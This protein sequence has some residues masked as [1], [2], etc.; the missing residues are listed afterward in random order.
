MDGALKLLSSTVIVA[1]A[2]VGGLCSCAVVIVDA[3][4]LRGLLELPDPLVAAHG[5]NSCGLL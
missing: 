3:I 1:G 4:V 2:I 5:R